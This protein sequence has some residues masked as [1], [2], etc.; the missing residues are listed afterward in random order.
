MVLWKA[1]AAPVAAGMLRR[2]ATSGSKEFASP[3][4]SEFRLRMEFA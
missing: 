3:F 2:S 1:Q 4:K